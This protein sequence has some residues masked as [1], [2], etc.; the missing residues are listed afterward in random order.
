MSDASKSEAGKPPRKIR[1][2]HRRR[3]MYRLSQG[4]ATV[5]GLAHDSG[6]RV[7]H[8]SAEIRRMRGDGL[9]SSDLPPG[10][11]GSRIRLTEKGW[12]IIEQDE[13][14][15][16]LSLENP[17]SSLDSC[18]IISRDE[19]NLTLCFLAPPEESMIQ[20]PNR[21]IPQSPDTISSTRNQGVSWSWA[22]LKERNP[23]WFD[24]D[25]F[26]VSDAPPELL[27]P[28]RIEAY[29]GR[30]PVYGL[31]RAT[32]LNEGSTSTISPGEWFSQPQQTQQATLDEPT[33]H[34]GGWLLGSPHSK[35]PDIR[36][37]QP[38]AAV[39]K[40]RLP[41][42]V[43]LRS[44]KANSLVLADLSGLEMNGHFY[45]IGALDYWIESAHPRISDS[46]R[47]K[48]ANSLKERISSSSRAKTPES[49]LRKFRKDWGDSEF[50]LE[51]DRI[52]LI[53]LRGLGNNAIEA[54]IR[55]SLD[56]KALPLVLEVK[57]GL[58]EDLLNNISTHE[59][60]RLIILEH[61]ETRFSSFDILEVDTVRTLPWLRFR[62]SSGTEI[63][64]RLVEQGKMTGMSEEVGHMGISPWEILGLESNISHFEIII[65]GNEVSI[66]RSALSQFPEGD[67][68]WA[69]QMEASYPLAA[70]IASPAKNRWQRWQRVSSRL[71]S[72]WL[73]LLDIDFLP[74]DRISEIADQAPDSV[75]LVFSKKITD[76]LRKDPNFLLRSWPAIDPKQ[77]NSGAAWLASHFIQN[78]AWLPKESYSDLI[79]WAIEAWLA[80]PPV[81]SLGALIGLEWLYRVTGQ[82]EKFELAIQRVRTRGESLPIGHQLNTWSRLCDYSM[83]EK[84]ADLEVIE[85]FMKDLPHSWWAAFSSVFLLEIL[86]GP[87]PERLMEI[88]VPW[89]PIILRPIGEES[90]APGL[91]SIKHPGCDPG[92]ISPLQNFL[93]SLYPEEEK[94]QLDSLRDLLDALLSVREGKTPPSGRSHQ[95]S[96]WLAQP[97]ESWPTFTPEMQMN[98][99]NFISERLILRRSGFNSRLS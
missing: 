44:A 45:P 70:W 48:R 40:E 47:R 18:C 22:V 93:K 65:S 30:S 51:E 94:Y 26:L 69:N 56:I 53:D 6:L 58:R 42:S 82:T 38:I 15:K 3:I 32:L 99:D 2:Q 16:V 60:L 35:S 11:R 52:R 17:P 41:R 68:V 23:R 76:K 78:S 12:D 55:W 25:N 43:L 97:I 49:T 63:P 7:P 1:S 95:L 31:I 13:W 86:N 20:I 50:S 81:E 5:S 64:I 90:D 8:A 27:G 66:V 89:C 96:G 79:D 33:Y 19:A 21:K 67:E 80:H 59:N 77:A 57:K 72:E 24:K 36:P 83:G 75:K 85:L 71:D 28:E 61:L 29:L 54:L 84:S 98:G 9:V 62:T 88:Q 92:I 34:R 87:N 37:T 74:I 73:A 4:D 14:S 91:S 46:E 10:S 39:I